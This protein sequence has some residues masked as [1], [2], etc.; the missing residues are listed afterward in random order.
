MI[1]IIG[2]AMVP[3]IIR[4]TMILVN[5]IIYKNRTY[6]LYLPKMTHTLG[7]VM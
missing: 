2:N 6:P 4:V 1:I 5:D 3:K 7:C